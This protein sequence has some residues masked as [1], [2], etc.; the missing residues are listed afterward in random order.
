[1]LPSAEAPPAQSLVRLTDNLVRVNGRLFVSADPV[2][3]TIRAD[4]G[5]R[6]QHAMKRVEIH[7]TL[8]RIK[9]KKLV[10]GGPPRLNLRIPNVVQELAP[11]VLNPSASDADLVRLSGKSRGQ[12]LPITDGALTSLLPE[13]L[14]PA[15][16]LDEER[17]VLRPAGPVSWFRQGSVRSGLS[18]NQRQKGIIDGASQLRVP[19]V[20][21][22]FYARGGRRWRTATPIE[23]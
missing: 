2:L 17:R 16:V 1:M 15:K 3:E 5:L 4:V 11:L 23:R 14:Y 8:R 9:S 7:N 6:L 22:G 10:A 20:V 19:V 13:G 21:E 12:G 18:A